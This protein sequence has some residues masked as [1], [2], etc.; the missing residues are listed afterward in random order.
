M[1][2]L[3]H[4]KNVLCE[5]AFTVNAEQAKKLVE[6][7]KAKKLFL[8]EAVWTRYFPLS[9]KIREM[10][11]SGVIGK[12]HRVTADLSIAE[13]KD[14]GSLDFPDSSRMVNMDLAGGALL[15][16]GIYSLTWVYQIL[17]HCQEGK[18]ER[19]TVLAAVQKYK[20]GADELTSV[21]LNWPGQ[22]SQGFATTSLRLATTPDGEGSSAAGPAARIQ[23][24]KGEI[25]VF[26]PLYRPL[27]YRIIMVGGKTGEVE[28]VHCPIPKDKE[29]QGKG[30]EGVGHGMFWEADEAARCLRDGKLESD[31]LNWEESIAIM[32][33]MDE[34]RKQGGLI[35]PEL[36]ETSLYD[37]KSPLNGEH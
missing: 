32:E 10:V 21:L 4:G 17:Y 28:D 31:T 20:T 1:L 2:A 8:M 33:T 3:E 19:P 15:D 25:Q 14:D 34:V 6:T 37:E 5:K 23:G 18:R 13:A 26:G 27:Q 35:Y 9:I 36:I 22:K 12:V 16:L 24:T 7:A 11:T 29:R 30:G